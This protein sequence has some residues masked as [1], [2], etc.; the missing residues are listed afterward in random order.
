MIKKP[1]R[2]LISSSLRSDVPLCVNTYDYAY[3]DPTDPSVPLP[4]SV[5]VTLNAPVKVSFPPLGVSGFTSSGNSFGVS[6]AYPALPFQVSNPARYQVQAVLS[7]SNTTSLTVS[8]ASDSASA[9]FEV[10]NCPV[11]AAPKLYDSGFYVRSDYKYLFS[12]YATVDGFLTSGGTSLKLR[13][14]LLVYSPI[15]F[16]PQT[17]GLT[18]FGFYGLNA[19]EPSGPF[20]SSISDTFQVDSVTSPTL[21]DISNGPVSLGTWSGA[22]GSGVSAGSAFVM[23]TTTFAFNL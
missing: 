7:S 10:K 16:L 19:G 5:G 22:S 21:V 20:T 12:T 13:T 23:G 4:S 11:P 8:R 3:A 14:L 2:A 18:G 6:S 17:F 9:V 1:S 15:K